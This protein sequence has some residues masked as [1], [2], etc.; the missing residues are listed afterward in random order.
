MNHCVTFACEAQKTIN[1]YI[2]LNALTVVN[3]HTPMNIL[4]STELYTLQG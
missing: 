3:R 2:L 1:A 4:Q